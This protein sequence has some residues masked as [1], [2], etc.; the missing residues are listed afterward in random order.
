MSKNACV[1]FEMKDVNRQGT[2]WH[3]G[4]CIV[5]Q[6][7][8]MAVYCEHMCSQSDVPNG[9][10]CSVEQAMDNHHKRFSVSPVI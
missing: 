7:H 5:E 2:Y 6:E 9:N 3:V 8:R 1:I 4:K 10:P